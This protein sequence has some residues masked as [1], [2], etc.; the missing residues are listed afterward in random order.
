[1]AASTKPLGG[2]AYGSIG[3]LPTSKLGPG[4]HCVNEGMARIC[5]VKA[6]DKHD[7]II[8][9]EKLD[10]SCVAVARMDGNLHPL[11]RSG[12]SA[13][14]SPYEQ[15]HLFDQ[16][17]RANTDR[18][19]SVVEDGEVIIGEWLAQSHGTKYDFTGRVMDPF[20]AFDIKRGKVRLPFNHF[21]SRVQSTFST[22]CLL[23]IGPPISIEMAMSEQGVKHWPH[24]E[25]E[26][27]VYR[28]ERKGAVDFLAKWVRSDY[29][30]GKHLPEI[31]GGA[32]V[33]NWR[34]A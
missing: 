10:G 32:A 1:M 23:S 28:V 21:M 30:P 3:H 16:W 5:T 34:P 12:Y 7:V 17:A 14:S 26:G 19:M 18:F 31:S 9:Q 24:E 15:H 4:D 13:L 20:A 29:V 6:R 8:A 33:W 25:P 27:V 2:K 11:T 22:P